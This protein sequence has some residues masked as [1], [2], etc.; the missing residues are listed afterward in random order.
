MDQRSEGDEQGKG[1]GRNGGREDDR[2]ANFKGGTLRRTPVSI[3]CTNN[4]QRDP[5]P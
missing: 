3:Q 4:P 1:R 5:C 2:E